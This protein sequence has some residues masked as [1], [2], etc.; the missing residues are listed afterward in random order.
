MLNWNE[1]NIYTNEELNNFVKPFAK[2]IKTSEDVVRKFLFE[3]NKTQIKMQ[4]YEKD[5]KR[6]YEEHATYWKMSY[7]IDTHP[8][9]QIM[10]LL[11][12]S[13]CETQ[14]E[15][16]SF[17][18]EKWFNR[19]RYLRI[20][21]YYDINQDKYMIKKQNENFMGNIEEK[22]FYTLRETLDYCRSKNYSYKY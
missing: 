18:H 15:F 12:E 7:N 11:P 19:M 4:K 22:T 17:N 6:K 2:A 21:I 20:G 13:A 9:Q 10:E 14:D 16:E 5:R 8:I 3:N 1:K